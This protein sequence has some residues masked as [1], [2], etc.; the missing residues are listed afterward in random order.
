M[1]ASYTFGV[2]AADVAAELPGIDASQIGASTEPVSTTDLTT[3]I[4]DGSAKLAALLASAGITASASMDADAHDTIAAAVREFAVYRAL[5]V[6]GV[7]GDR[8]REAREAWQITWA[9]YS[10][11][12]EQLGDAYTDGLTVTVDTDDTA[13]GWTFINSEGSVW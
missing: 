6:M 7:G 13:E 9:L 1:A 8:L 10:N 2:V 3:W 12:P 4:N 5:L 11:R